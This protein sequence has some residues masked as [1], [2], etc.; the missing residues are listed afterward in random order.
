[1]ATIAE[2][3]LPHRCKTKLALKKP[4]EGEEG[5]KK[6][7]ASLV[8][9]DPSRSP[10]RRVPKG[11]PIFV[12]GVMFINRASQEERGVAGFIRGHETKESS[13]K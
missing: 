5:A 8:F 1:M 12:R 13:T 7:E 2:R 6:G 9:G 4:G 11:Y 3:I 10:E